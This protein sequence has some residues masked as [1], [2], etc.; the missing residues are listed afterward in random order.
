MLKMLISLPKL[1]NAM[2]INMAVLRLSPEHSDPMH[3]FPANPQNKT[4][5][6]T[7]YKYL[8]FRFIRGAVP[9]RILQLSELMIG[10]WEIR[11]MAKLIIA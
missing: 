5:P 10:Q 6:K 11:Q 3:L 8:S 1:S 2:I 7:K 9:P 4:L